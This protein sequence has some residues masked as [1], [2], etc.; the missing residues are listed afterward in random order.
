MR[1]TRLLALLKARYPVGVSLPLIIMWA[2]IV[3]PLGRFS[4]LPETIVIWRV[5]ALKTQKGAVILY[6]LRYELGTEDRV[7]TPDLTTYPAASNSA[8][9]VARFFAALSDTEWVYFVRFAGACLISIFIFGFL[10]LVFIAGS[11][12]RWRCAN[13]PKTPRG[14]KENNSRSV[15]INLGKSLYK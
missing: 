7:D 8:M 1:S 6:A 13:N 2:G 9:R 5:S 4:S 12:S 14:L 3:A 10:F 15:K 11:H